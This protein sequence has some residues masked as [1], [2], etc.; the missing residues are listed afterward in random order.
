MQ[1]DRQDAHG[2]EIYDYLNG[3]VGYEIV[4]RD[5]GYIDASGAARN[6]F[7]EYKDWAP[8]QIL[9][10]GCHVAKLFSTN[11]SRRTRF[12]LVVCCLLNLGRF[13]HLA[14]ARLDG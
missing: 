7:A 13:G 4:E 6:Y 3:K 12:R 1:K 9:P 10:L 5:D 14:G 11:C 2:H 8:D